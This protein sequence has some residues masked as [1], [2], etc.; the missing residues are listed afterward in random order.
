MARHIRN[1]WSAF[2]LI[3][4]LV[5]I[6]I[7]AILAGM[8]LP[9][10]AAAREKARRSSCVGNAQQMGVALASYTSDYS[11]Y[12]PSNPSWQPL[13]WDGTN[14]VVPA[15]TW[16]GGVDRG[17]YTSAKDGNA[18]YQVATTGHDYNA[19]TGGTYVPVRYP[20]ELQTLACGGRISNSTTWTQAAGALNA[21]PMGLGYLVT[22]GY[23]P[24]LRA[25]YCPS[26]DAMPRMWPG[27]GSNVL[28]D[29]FAAGAGWLARDLKTLGGTDATA[30]THGN[31]RAVIKSHLAPFPGYDGLADSGYYSSKVNGQYAYRGMPVDATD[32]SPDNQ[33]CPVVV[34]RIPGVKPNLAWVTSGTNW[35]T[36]LGRP[37]FKTTKMLGGRA[38]VTDLFGHVWDGTTTT[39]SYD[40]R[41][42]AGIWAHRDGYNV[43][44]GDNHVAWFGDPQ[45]QIIWRAQGTGPASLGGQFAR[46]GSQWGFTRL[47]KF[48]GGLVLAARDM[49]NDTG[50][51]AWHGFDN[52]AGIDMNVDY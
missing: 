28:T 17:W 26:A 22:G 40:V 36:A 24:D 38:I 25:F 16:Q 10:L 12:F 41:A 7:I 37:I 51:L 2:T 4:L 11:D 42:G 46:T 32:Y 15:G 52:A 29:A 30:L 9:A 35:Q 45:Q 6:A 18:Q 50:L 49:A 3:E 47:D 39:A 14:K 8:L 5:V 48:N 19:S 27:G 44:Y 23:M 33:S 1:L 13:F 20:L 43:L 34:P 31:Y 21:G